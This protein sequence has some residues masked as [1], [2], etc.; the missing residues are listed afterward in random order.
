M[1]FLMYTSSLELWT[2]SILTLI[3]IG[4]ILLGKTPGMPF[5]GTLVLGGIIFILYGNHCTHDKK[6]Y[7]LKRFSEGRA[8]ECGLWRG[9]GV[10]VDPN[11]GWRWE[12]QIGFVK[13][14]H[15]R[16]DPQLCHVIGEDAPEPSSFA[17][18]LIYISTVL[19]LLSFRSLSIPWRESLDKEIERIEHEE[20][21]TEKEI[22]TSKDEPCNR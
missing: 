8:L 16:N 13:N 12:K 5:I 19:T 17:Y 15:V 18:W 7:I 9:E 11:N 21:H 4:F 3:G 1:N 10:L 2:L 14:D 22:N 20:L 6:D